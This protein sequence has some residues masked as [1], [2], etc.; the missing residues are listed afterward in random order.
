MFEKLKHKIFLRADAGQNIGYG[1][2]IRSSALADMLKDD[3][4]VLFATVNP[5]DYQKHELS[6]VCPCISLN[7][8]THF[9]DFLSMLK[10]DEIVVL[11]NYFFT[12][13]YQRAVKEK[14]CKLVCIDDMHDKHYVADLIVAQGEV[15][16][17][18]YSTESYTRFC[19]GYDWLLLRNPFLE[20]YKKNS[21]RNYS[22]LF[23]RIVVGFG[24]ADMYN[25][26]EKTLQ[27]LIKQKCIQTVDVIIG[28]ASQLKNSFITTKELNFHR[29]ISASHIAQLFSSCDIAILPTSTICLEALVCKTRIAG[30]FYVDNQEEFY[31]YL[32]KANII[33][34]MGNFLQESYTDKLEQLFIYDATV[35]NP[36][37]IHLNDLKERYIY[38]FKTLL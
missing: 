23:Q 28:D 13:D 35:L 29:N 22:P 24:G 34:G 3:F 31:Q 1:H 6:N 27:I 33:Y 15:S 21:H 14:G 36:F 2:F 11:D 16:R 30:G 7:S 32:D 17:Y 26:T 18:M 37:P 5:T 9:E 4:D 38:I 8:E 10:G 20:A 19:L 12:T 25:L